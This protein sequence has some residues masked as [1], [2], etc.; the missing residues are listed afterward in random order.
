MCE[1]KELE[2][3]YT[4]SLCIQR[5]KFMFLYSILNNKGGY[6]KKCNFVFFSEKN[7]GLYSAQPYLIYTRLKYNLKK[8]GKPKM[9]LKIMVKKCFLKKSFI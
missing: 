5:N 4:L 6:V 2:Q 8:Y 3:I 1:K 9:L 7:V